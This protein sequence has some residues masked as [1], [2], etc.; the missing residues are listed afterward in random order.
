VRLVT[1][2]FSVK[3]VN[4]RNGDRNAC[5]R[6]AGSAASG[7]GRG[8]VRQPQICRL[9]LYRSSVCGNYG[10]SSAADLE[11]ANQKVDDE[12]EQEREPERNNEAP[13]RTAVD[14]DTSAGGVAS[15]KEIPPPHTHKVSSF[16][17]LETGATIASFRRLKGVF[18][19]A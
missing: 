14:A 18:S 3:R 15:A 2:L 13:W 1:I 7:R 6:A 9:G 17:P 11:R 10:T 8:S 16:D 4:G 12:R 5:G 19:R